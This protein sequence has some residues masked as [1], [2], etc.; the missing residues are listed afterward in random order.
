MKG[1]LCPILVNCKYDAEFWHELLLPEWIPTRKCG[2]P[3][4]A[5]VHTAGK[6]NSVEI[7]YAISFRC[8][9]QHI[10][11]SVPSS[12]FLARPCGAGPDI[13]THLCRAL[14]FQ[15]APKG[16]W[17]WRKMENHLRWNWKGPRSLKEIVTV[18]KAATGGFA[19]PMPFKCGC[20]L[21]QC[22][23]DAT[24]KKWWKVWERYMHCVAWQGMR[25]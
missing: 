2:H 18:S 11:R 22:C 8:D 16:N 25:R 3:K 14:S 15:N 1:L 5:P 6:V 12:F 20:P 4:T 13:L 7:T 24:T 17:N 9:G 10:T 21:P 19:R 23:K